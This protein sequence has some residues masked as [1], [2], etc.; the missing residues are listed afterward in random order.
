MK[1]TTI[2]TR[3][4][5]LFRNVGEGVV[6]TDNM[7]DYY[8]KI[9]LCIDSYENEHNSVNLATGKLEGFF[10]DAEVHIVEAELKVVL[11]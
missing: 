5:T 9:P 10:E 3:N 11:K 1:I 6:F 8:I 7:I 2:N 4:K